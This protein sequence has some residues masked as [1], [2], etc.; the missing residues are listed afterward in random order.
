MPKPILLFARQE[1]K[2]TK[3]LF[4]PTS[5]AYFLELNIFNTEV[6][7]FLHCSPKLK[8]AYKC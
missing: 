6:C 3:T 4:C 5:S 1:K 2:K 8:F 7:A